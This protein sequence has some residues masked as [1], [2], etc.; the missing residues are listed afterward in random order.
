MKALTIAELAHALTL[1]D[2]FILLT[3]RRPDGDTIGSAVALC[4]ALRGLGKTASLLDNPQFTPKYRPF[5]EGLTVEAVP[6]NACLVAVD[7]AAVQ[8]L[9][10]S[11]LPYAAGISFLIDHHERSG[12]YAAEGHVDPRA[13]ACG[14]LIFALL[15]QLGVQLSAPI[16][17]AIYVA[18][19]TDTGC[20]RF[21]NTTANTLRVAAAC[22]ECGADTF[23]INQVMFLTKRFARL[24]LEAYLTETTALYANGLVAISQVSNDVRS[25]LGITEDDIEDISGFGRAIE[26][27]EIAIMLRQEGE[28]TKL[29]VRTSPRYHASSICAEL[30]GGGHAAAAGATY[31]GSLKATQEEILRVLKKQGIAI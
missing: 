7:T 8:M 17:E 25:E 29:S 10:Y 28:Q 22:K 2:N 11:A 6:E 4:R 15:Q 13:A 12:A 5:Y 3:H 20:F 30:G 18:V 1:R 21:S 26:G 14:E 16:A 19:S 23:A 9:S 27:V 31:D 24:K